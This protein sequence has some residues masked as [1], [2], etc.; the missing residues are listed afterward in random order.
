MTLFLLR[1][2]R[3]RLLQNVTAASQTARARSRK[4]GQKLAIEGTGLQSRQS[5]NARPD[6]QL[7]HK[8]RSAEGAGW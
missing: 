8:I 7:L 1:R 5:S 3:A 6:Q 2:L 4:F